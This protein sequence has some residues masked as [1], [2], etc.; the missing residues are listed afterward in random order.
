MPE[1]KRAS[2]SAPTIKIT[3]S[4]TKAGKP[5]CIQD[6]S[7][8]SIK[9]TPRSPLHMAAVASRTLPKALWAARV[10]L[11]ASTKWPLPLPRAAQRGLWDSMATALAR[12]LTKDFTELGV[13]RSHIIARRACCGARGRG[14]L[15]VPA[16][17]ARAGFRYIDIYTL[18][19][20]RAGSTHLIIDS[21]N[22]KH[23]FVSVWPA[24]CLGHGMAVSDATTSIQV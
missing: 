14:E 16:D 9:L 23:V 21:N 18:K 13:Q 1:R 4:E 2:R 5:L 20:T 15:Y 11:C 19:Q 24:I 6:A 17:S 10:A 7:D 3:G 22:Q 12:T 8:I